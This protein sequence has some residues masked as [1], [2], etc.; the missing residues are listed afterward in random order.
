VKSL[1]KVSEERS[2]LKQTNTRGITGI[3]KVSIKEHQNMP[4][5]DIAPS[6]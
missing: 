1:S 2:E 6:T 3:G 5:M 4:P